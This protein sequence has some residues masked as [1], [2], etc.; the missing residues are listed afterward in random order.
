M[1]R[2]LRFDRLSVGLDARL[3]AAVL[4][5]FDVD[6]ADCITERAP[7]VLRKNF[8]EPIPES[9]LVKGSSTD[10]RIRIALVQARVEQCRWRARP[11]V[12]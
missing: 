12:Y 5:D 9:Q 6:L 10:H 11:P 8:V 2:C 3:C 7:S 4:V 1:V